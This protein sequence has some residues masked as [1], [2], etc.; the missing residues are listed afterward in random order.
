MDSFQVLY[1]F[2]TTAADVI[3]ILSQ[4]YMAFP[5]PRG[6]VWLFTSSAYP[7]QNKSPDFI[8]T[9]IMNFRFQNCSD[10]G[11]SSI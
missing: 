2:F 8:M 3:R 5:T 7:S 11:I 6:F 4:F 10:L 9:T 1:G